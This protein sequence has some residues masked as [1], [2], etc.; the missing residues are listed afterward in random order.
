MTANFKKKLVLLLEAFKSLPEG[1]SI[2]L[3]LRT[4]HTKIVLLCG[5]FAPLFFKI[6]SSKSFLPW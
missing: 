3:P 5:K 2:K 1:K 6:S 4:D